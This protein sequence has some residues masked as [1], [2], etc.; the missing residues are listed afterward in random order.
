MLSELFDFPRPPTVVL[1]VIVL[2]ILAVGAFFLFRF[3]RT[4][5]F[6]QSKL[7]PLGGKAAFW[8]TTAYLLLPFDL[9]PEPLVLDDIVLMA[10]TTSYI[11]GL[12]KSRGIIGGDDDEVDGPVDDQ[13]GNI[14]ELPGGGLSMGPPGDGSPSE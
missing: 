14:D 2:A 12:A 9:L 8:G 4:F 5:R 6:V 11:M 10:A 7:M 13:V 1:V 3:I